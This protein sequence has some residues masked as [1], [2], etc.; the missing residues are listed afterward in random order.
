MNREFLLE[1]IVQ[2]LDKADDRA[3]DLIWRFVRALLKEV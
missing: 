2:L 3:L 1:R